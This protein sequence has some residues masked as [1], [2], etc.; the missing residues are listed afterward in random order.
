MKFPQPELYYRSPLSKPVLSCI[1]LAG[2]K[3]PRI[4][5]LGIPTLHSMSQEVKS[6]VARVRLC[7]HTCTAYIYIY[8]ERDDD[9]FYTG[10]VTDWHAETGEHTVEY[11]DGDVSTEVLGGRDAPYWEV[12]VV[13]SPVPA[14]GYYLP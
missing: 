9:V 11:D 3:A 1:Y 6:L 4:S 10:R 12:V 5:A 7:A 13:A 2:G 8:R 14:G